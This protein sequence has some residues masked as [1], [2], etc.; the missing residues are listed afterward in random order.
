MQ[1]VSATTIMRFIGQQLTED[2]ECGALRHLP[3]TESNMSEGQERNNTGKDNT[4]RH[5]SAPANTIDRL[6]YREF[7]QY[8]LIQMSPNEKSLQF[9]GLLL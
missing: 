3:L 2:T 9:L 5:W 6:M 8:V 1:Q 4:E 7:P